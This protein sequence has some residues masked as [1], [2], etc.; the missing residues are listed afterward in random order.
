MR[1]LAIPIPIAEVPS[2]ANTMSSHTVIEIKVLNSDASLQLKAC[3][4]PHGNE[5]NL[6]AELRKDC[7]ICPPA[8]TRMVLSMAIRHLWKLTKLDVKST[9]LQ[10]GPAQRDAYVAPPCESKDRGTRL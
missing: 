4:A 5:D 7:C 2:D 9:F 1:T 6:K 3:I 8:R 10:T